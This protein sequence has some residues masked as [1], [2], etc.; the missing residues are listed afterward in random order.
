MALYG[1]AQRSNPQ[2]VVTYSPTQQFEGQ[3][4][5]IGNMTAGL[6][7]VKAMTGTLGTD[8]ASDTVDRILNVTVTKQ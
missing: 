5:V 6:D 3:F 1:S 2:F 4:S 8:T 7:I